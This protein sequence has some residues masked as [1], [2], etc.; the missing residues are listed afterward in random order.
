MS[1]L[2]ISI[3]LDE[4]EE[5]NLASLLKRYGGKAPEYFRML[6][7]ESYRKEFGG[8]KSRK[9]KIQ[10][11]PEEDLT[12]EQICEGVGGKVS[13]RNDGM[14]VCLMKLASGFERSLPV[15]MTKEIQDYA[16]YNELRKD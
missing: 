1:K 16:K 8:Y 10:E 15:T 11:I 5:K 12:P 7:K 14:V 9:I 3:F 4:V 13:K 2:R 6:L